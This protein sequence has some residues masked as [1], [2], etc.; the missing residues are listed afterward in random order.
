MIN[1]ST[2]QNLFCVSLGCHAVIRVSCRK[3]LDICNLS[4]TISCL[5]AGGYRL[6]NADY[7][8][9]ALGYFQQPRIRQGVNSPE[10]VTFHFTP[11]FD[12]T[13]R[14]TKIFFVVIRP[15]YTVLSN[16]MKDRKFAKLDGKL[17]HWNKYRFPA[18]WIIW[19]TSTGVTECS[20]RVVTRS[21][22]CP[23]FPL[24]CYFKK[25]S[26]LNLFH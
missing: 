17:N 19:S 23:V 16:T 10:A 25:K 15:K 21:R 8:L 22:N 1:C 3:V 4:L 24:R 9:V 13:E 7:W 12:Q 5:V 2:Q 18:T 6:V 26:F 11:A 20:S 14:C